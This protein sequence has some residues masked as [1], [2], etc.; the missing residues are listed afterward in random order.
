MCLFGT[1]NDSSISGI[2]V[3]RGQELAFEVSASDNTTIK[4]IVWDIVKE[5]FVYYQIFMVYVMKLCFCL[6]QLSQDWQIDYE[7]YQW[8]KL[9]P[10]TEDTK[11]LV[12]QYLSWSGTDKQS[13]KFNQGK[14]FK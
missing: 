4:S 2:W 12:H 8:T 14:I 1:D 11:K 10:S 7:S 13:R 5:N 6:L 9:D 3:W